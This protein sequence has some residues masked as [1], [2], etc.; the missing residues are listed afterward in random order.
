[1]NPKT[2]D[3]EKTASS[4]NTTGKTGYPHVEGTRSLSFTLYK[5]QLKVDQRPNIRPETTPGNS[6]KYSVTNRYRE[7]LPK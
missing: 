6:R 4:T 5:N 1:M 3:E 7:R 2:H